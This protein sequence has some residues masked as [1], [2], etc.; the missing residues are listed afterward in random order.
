MLELMGSGYA[1]I[2]E[3]IRVSTWELTEAFPGTAEEREEKKRRVVLELELRTMEVNSF[4]KKNEERSL[5][6]ARWARLD[7][8]R[9]VERERKAREDEFLA[10]HKRMTDLLSKFV[11][12]NIADSSTQSNDNGEA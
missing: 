9:A 10:D 11:S 1:A 6:C 12:R 7:E 4:V 3:D 8:E 5:E 2:R